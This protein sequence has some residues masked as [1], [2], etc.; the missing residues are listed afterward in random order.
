M[1]FIK[2]IKEPQAEGLL[3]RLYSSLGGLEEDS[4]A[5]ILKIHSLCPDTLKAH[6]MLYRTIMFGESTLSRAEREMIATVVSSVNQCV[7]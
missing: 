2:V 5:N 4:V 6:L 7:Y 3:K 1:A